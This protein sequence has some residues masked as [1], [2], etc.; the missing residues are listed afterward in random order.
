M[1][2]LDYLSTMPDEKALLLSGTMNVL[3]EIR[4]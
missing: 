3:D 4:N 2:A 1:R